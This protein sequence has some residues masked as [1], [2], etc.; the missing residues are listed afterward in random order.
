M[1]PQKIELGRFRI[2][3]VRIFEVYL[4]M[5]LDHVPGG[6]HCRWVNGHICSFF[7]VTLK[8]IRVLKPIVH[9]EQRVHVPIMTLRK[10]IQHIRVNFPA[11]KHESC[12]VWPLMTPCVYI[13]DVVYKSS[14]YGPYK[15]R[16]SSSIIK[17]VLCSELCFGW[18][19]VRSP[20]E[21][22]GDQTK[23]L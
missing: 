6:T 17:E 13:L 3:I 22:R 14:L 23:A 10:V 9:T 16:L 8:I 15:S 5:A 18:R 7:R 12:T 11:G 2:T 19:I 1:S 20:Q 21:R 4:Y